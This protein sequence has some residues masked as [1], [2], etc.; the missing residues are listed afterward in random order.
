MKKIHQRDYAD[1]TWYQTPRNFKR[2]AIDATAYALMT[3]FVVW[4]I[5]KFASA[6]VGA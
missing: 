1:K 5:F 3:V 4:V 6:M 2:E